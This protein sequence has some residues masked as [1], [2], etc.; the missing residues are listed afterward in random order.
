MC[1]RTILRYLR[2]ARES[3]YYKEYRRSAPP[4]TI[5]VF[6]RDPN[7]TKTSFIR[8]AQIANF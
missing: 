7:D 4:F 5:Y 3:D 6:M 2:G 1:E 8:F